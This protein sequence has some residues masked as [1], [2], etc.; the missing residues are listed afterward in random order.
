MMKTEVMIT[1]HSDLSIKVC[2]LPYKSVRSIERES[3][4]SHAYVGPML[5]VSDELSKISVD[6]IHT[7]FYSIECH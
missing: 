7:D 1:K 2:M 3:G 5:S 4:D 6:E